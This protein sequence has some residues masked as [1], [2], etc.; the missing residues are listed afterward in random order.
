MNSETSNSIHEQHRAQSEP[1]IRWPRVLFRQFLVACVCITSS[2]LFI[3]GSRG[4][5]AA[6]ITGFELPQ[7]T[8]TRLCLSILLPCLLL[9]ILIAVILLQVV[10]ENVRARVF[11]NR[12]AIAVSLVCLVTY[13]MTVVFPVLRLVDQ[14]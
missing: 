9:F 1:D 2:L 6:L 12:M 8:V 10:S 13:V 11:W 3:A 7:S 14:L 4:R 5:L